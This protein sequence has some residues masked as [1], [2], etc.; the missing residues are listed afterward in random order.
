M[1]RGG[2]WKRPEITQRW[3]LKALQLA[4]PRHA[5]RPSHT[6]AFTKQWTVMY[7][8]YSFAALIF[9]VQAAVAAVLFRYGGALTNF[10]KANCQLWRHRAALDRVLFPSPP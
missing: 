6:L 2:A 10:V 7:N 4:M 9:E 3:Y 1:R 8:S 5:R